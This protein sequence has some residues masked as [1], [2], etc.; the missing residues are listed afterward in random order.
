MATTNFDKSFKSILKQEGGYVDHP[1]D[2]GGA[3]N[4]GITLKTLENYRGTPVSKEDLKSLKDSEIKAIYESKYWNSI[5]GSNI[6]DPEIANMIFDQ[7]VNKGSRVKNHVQQL[8]GVPVDGIMGVGT[9]NKINS[10]S[11][12][13]RKVFKENFIQ[14]E[15]DDY[16]ELVKNKPK[17]KVFYNGWMKRLGNL[18]KESGVKFT[19][20]TTND[21]QAD[22]S[23]HKAFFKSEFV[24]D[25]ED[26]LESYEDNQELRVKSGYFRFNDLVYSIPPESINILTDEFEQSIL[27]MRT[28]VPT[29]IQGGRKR[30]RLIVSFP[31]DLND[32]E[33][34][35]FISRLLI[36]IRKTPI[37]TIDNEKIRKELFGTSSTMTNVGVVVDNINGYIDED[38]PNLLRCTLQMSW[39]NHIPFVDEI[40]YV[41]LLPNGQKI[42][43]KYPSKLY[44]KFYKEGTF[45]KDS[46]FINDMSTNYIGQ[47]SLFILYKEYASFDNVYTFQKPKDTLSKLESGRKIITSENY[48]RI[49]ELEKQGWYIAEDQER[50]EDMP[51]EGV[52]YRWKSFE[53]PFSD[54]SQYGGLLL[55]NMSFSLSTNPSYISLEQYGVPTVQFLGGSAA[56][57]RA[58]IF[59]D[60]EKNLVDD[61]TKEAIPSGTSNKLA[62]LQGIFRSVS[63]DRSRFPK[64]SKENHLMISHPLAK[65]MKYK[66]TGFATELNYYDE[67]GRQHKFNPD[68]FLPVIVANTASS[69]ITGLPYA[70][71]YQIDFK[72]TRFARNQKNIKYKGDA[73]S[74]NNKNVYKKI[75]E[76]LISRSGISY[77]KGTKQYVINSRTKSLNGESIHASKLKVAL[78]NLLI[79]DKEATTIEK[80]FN[81]PYFFYSY[82]EAKSRHRKAG[83]AT[84]QTVSQR[85]LFEKNRQAALNRQNAQLKMSRGKIQKPLTQQDIEDI[86]RYQS[87]D[88]SVVLK[89]MPPFYFSK[90]FIINDFLLMFYLDFIKSMQNADLWPQDYVDEFDE[91]IN[92]HSNGSK[93]LYKDMMIPAS[94]DNP[95]FYFADGSLRV[96]NYKNRI[97]KNLPAVSI[98]SDKAMQKVALD[99]NFTKNN[100][101]PDLKTGRTNFEVARNLFVNGDHKDKGLSAIH[102]A[103]DQTYRVFQS[104]KAIANMTPYSHSLSQIYPTFQI[105]LFSDRY[106]FL[107][108]YSAADVNAKELFAE[109]EKDLLDLFELSSIIDIRIIKDQDEAADVMVIR[110]LNTNKYDLSTLGDPTFDP[111][112]FSVSRLISDIASGKSIISKT[113]D[114][115]LE[116]SGLKEGIK[117]KALLGYSASADNLSVE[118]SGRIA[119]INGRDIIEIYAVGNGHEL[120]QNTLGLDKYS[121][122]SDTGD[123]I[124]KILETS[125]EVKSFGNTGLEAFKGIVV[126]SLLMMGGRSALDNVYAP[127]AHPSGNFFKNFV[128]GNVNGVLKTLTFVPAAIGLGTMIPFIGPVVFE[129]AIGGLI[130][131][132]GGIIG[133]LG[134]AAALAATAVAVSSAKE[135]YRFFKNKIVPAKFIVF[136]QTIWDVLQELTLRHPGYICAVV[137]FD[138]RS[139][140]YFG[141][142]DSPYFFRGPQSTLEKT[143]KAVNT[144]AP[145]ITM[146]ELSDGKAKYADMKWIAGIDDPTMA[147]SNASAKER[148]KTLE[149]K[150]K[151]SLKTT[152]IEMLSLLEMQKSFRTYHLVTSEHDIISNQIEASSVDVANSVQIYHPASSS[153]AVP[154]NGQQYIEDYELTDPMKADDDIYSHL[155][156]NKIFTFHNAH[157]DT[158]GLELP[159]KYAKAILCK[160]LEKIYKGKI[161]LLG[162]PGIKPHDILILRDTYNQMSGPVAVAKVSQILAPSEGWITVVYPKFI[163]IPDT[164]AGAFQMSNVLKAARYL[165]ADEVG[166]FYTSMQKF[167]PNE[168]TGSAKKDEDFSKAWEQTFST[169]QNTFEKADMEDGELLQQTLKKGGKAGVSLTSTYVGQ[170]VVAPK[171]FESAKAGFEATKAAAKGLSSTVQTGVATKNVGGLLV[172]GGSQLLS[173]GGKGATTIFKAGTGIAAKSMGL[174]VDYA[175]NSAIEGF[176]NWSKYREPIYVFPLK[177]DGTPF[178]AA[179]NGFKENTLLDHLLYQATQGGDKMGAMIYYVR[180]FFNGWVGEAPVKSRISNGEKIAKVKDGDSVVL[181]TNEELRLSGYDSGETHPNKDHIPDAAEIAMGEEAQRVLEELIK[182]NAN[183][184]VSVERKGVDR[185]QRTV[186]RININD[187]DVSD[188]LINYR[189]PNGGQLVFIYNGEP[190]YDFN[191]KDKVNNS[192]LR[193]WEQVAINY[194]GKEKW[195]QL[196]PNY[197][198]KFNQYKANYKGQ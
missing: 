2:P 99:K 119:A 64:F 90:F 82:D 167:N 19:P 120:I 192:I 114:S 54:I 97:I 71:K 166:L 113:Y 21:L 193:N 3:T 138:N 66:A 194:F 141:E 164:S 186:A 125:K 115:N 12:E 18:A 103:N 96:T 44:E 50:H 43:Q 95:A 101:N 39:F 49:K 87:R 23:S 20:P 37:A 77:D 154:G 135:V 121:L 149:E 132:G 116:R 145:R 98:S 15:L 183:T 126:P 93:D 100:L 112:Q 105:Q 129:I 11:D 74:D 102:D 7:Y 5:G 4:K 161:V 84:S 182:N 72:E 45:I 165:L 188:Y 80:A 198:T 38:Y 134:L 118:F 110:I 94:E 153:D 152:N 117:I 34:R 26:F 41:E 111:K 181:E 65:L 92:Y 59:A 184:N 22:N 16:N 185:Y 57:L 187:I 53:I 127:T 171:A 25:A 174:I 158:E 137:P 89:A 151:D 8:L 33:G 52:F 32:D 160:E 191:S 163:A 143:I 9:I 197:M 128:A 91:Y 148:I 73:G 28:E 78:N 62:E 104:Q 169:P 70:S 196:K 60:A 10:L 36:Q 76:K 170:T 123:L 124:A 150:R 107:Q 173:V 67:N 14:K 178:M 63:E 42:Y 147:T 195:T 130:A 122:N 58:I 79:L 175:V 190:K 35:S 1:D 86:K 56:E 30:I 24:P 88:N 157:E 140:I 17:L 159:Q 106:N 81:S 133:A 136:Q 142:P 109:D 46:Y 40:K 55:Q 189:S 131:F 85:V 177:K 162:R 155:I 68:H 6:N 172:N 27:L 13:E 75:T 47:N 179:L 168:N 108:K 51:I 146:R 69:T 61:S 31:V 48:T 156:N 180:D 29:S 176:V 144:S 83:E 139:T